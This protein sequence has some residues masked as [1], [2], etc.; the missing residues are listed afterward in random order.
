LSA[1]KKSN[2]TVKAVFLCLASAL[3]IAIAQVKNDPKYTSYTDGYGLKQH[4]EKLLKASGVDL[5]NSGV[6]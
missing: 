2:V 5:P 3:I 4:V 6:F 1:I